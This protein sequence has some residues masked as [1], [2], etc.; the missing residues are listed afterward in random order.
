[1]EKRKRARTEK[2]ERRMKV[3]LAKMTKKLFT[4]WMHNI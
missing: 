4:I 3:N 2:H 1:M